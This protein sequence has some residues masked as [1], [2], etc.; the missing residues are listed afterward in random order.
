M[1]FIGRCFICGKYG[2]CDKHHIF[3][4]HGMRGKSEEDQCFVYL[5][6][7][8]HDQVHRNA[9]LRILL[10]KFGQLIFER[11]ETHDAFMGRYRK[12]YLDAE[13]TME[14]V[15]ERIGEYGRKK[16]VCQNHMRK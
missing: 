11:W 5:C 13:D 15:T 7:E 6:R 4:G 1:G 2:E 10:K 14:N 12:N 16:N 3:N 9:D 8:C